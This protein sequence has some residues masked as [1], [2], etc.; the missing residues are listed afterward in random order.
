M[1]RR[2]S[3]S[4]DLI[5]Q[6]PTPQ[7]LAQELMKQAKAGNKNV[8]DAL[9]KTQEE[10][11]KEEAAYQKQIQ[12]DYGTML[13]TQRTGLNTYANQLPITEA[14]I[15]KAQNQFNAT[16]YGT[17]A[18][19]YDTNMTTAKDLIL[20]KVKSD[21]EANSPVTQEKLKQGQQKL[22]I[23]QQNADTARAGATSNILTSAP[24]NPQGFG[25]AAQTVPAIRNILGQ[26]TVPETQDMFGLKPQKD[27]SPQMF[28][29]MD[30]FRTD[31]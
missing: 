14:D 19:V 5:A 6:M 12:S 10:R 28:R 17:D 3:I 20:P 24:F 26:P 30:L 29:F 23:L 15:V 27:N 2:L 1:A 16:R 18:D 21:V 4:P 25:T 11:M 9:Q 31:D 7:Q 22:K 13:N 8:I